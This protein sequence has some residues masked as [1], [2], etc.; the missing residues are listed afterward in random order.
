MKLKVLGSSSA[1][2]GYILDNGKEALIIEAGTPMSAVKKAV[3][4]DIKRIV[5]CLISHEHGDH[6]KNAKLY[7]Y[8]GITIYASRGTLGALGINPNDGY[9]KVSYFSSSFK[10][11]NFIISPF[12]IHHDSAEPYGYVI[13]HEETG[14]I[15][16]VTDTCFLEYKFT[17]LN[18]IMI[19][20]NY[21]KDILDENYKSGL[22]PKKQRDR[23]I[24]SHMDYDT[25]L[26][27]LKDNDLSRVYNIVLIHLS[28]K[29]SN[30]V[31]FQ[32]GIYEATGKNVFIAEKGM[33]IEFGR[34]PF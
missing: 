20:C 11:G 27:V 19:E 21:R 10:A 25:C 12:Q 24:E 33:V 2:N 7:K 23:T 34:S 18:N 14:N 5:G 1:G 6:A 4:Y 30:A 17:G 9:V 29:N 31:E 8:H 26:R 28:D 15:L 16:F 32:R 22:I 13:Y 3:N